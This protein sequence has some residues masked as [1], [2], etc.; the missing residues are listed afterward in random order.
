[1]IFWHETYIKRLLKI[2]KYESEDLVNKLKKE[3][4]QL[5][6]AMVKIIIKI[7]D[8]DEMGVSSKYSI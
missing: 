3:T 5:V 2:Q 1:M 4:K 7:L 8:F 6:S